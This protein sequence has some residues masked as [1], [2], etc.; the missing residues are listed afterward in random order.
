MGIKVF[1]VAREM[2]GIDSLVEGDAH[3]EECVEWYE[4]EGGVA[5]VVGIVEVEEVEECLCKT[6][7]A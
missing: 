4:R 7:S 2:S 1:C 3:R 6:E 5:A